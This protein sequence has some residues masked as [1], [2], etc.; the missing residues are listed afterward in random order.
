MTPATTVETTLKPKK[1][2]HE[3]HMTGVAL[4]IYN[5]FWRLSK[6]SKT[7]TIS[8]TNSRIATLIGQRCEGKRADYITRAKMALVRAGWLRYEGV[9]KVSGTGT[10]QGGRYAVVSHEEWAK[11]QSFLLGHSP[12][13]PKPIA[14]VVASVHPGGRSF[15]KS[16]L[17]FAEARTASGVQSLP[18]DKNRAGEEARTDLL[19]G[20]THG[21]RV[22]KHAHSVDSLTVDIQTVDATAELPPVAM[23]VTAIAD[24]PKVN[25]PGQE[26]PEEAEYVQ[27]R[28]FLKEQAAAMIARY[29]A[30]PRTTETSGKPEAE[31][32][33]AVAAASGN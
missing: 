12:C 4:K 20:S 33:L 16:K 22:G 14:V 32:I 13:Q 31:D 23:R 19:P 21:A 17:R 9:S 26:D 7:R 25:P 1:C 6:K 8:I 30:G 5:L 2:H 3:R 11:R 15:G 10:W 28:A 18:P 29:G 24:K 27:R